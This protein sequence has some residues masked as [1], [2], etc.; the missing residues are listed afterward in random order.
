VEEAEQFLEWALVHP[1]G[2]VDLSA[3][4]HLHTALLQLLLQLK[5]TVIGLPPDRVL[6]SFINGKDNSE[7]GGS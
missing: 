6:R 2:A 1:D 7:A 4:D 5:P 3:V